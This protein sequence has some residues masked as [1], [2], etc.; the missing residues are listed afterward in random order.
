MDDYGKVKQFLEE[1]GPS[2]ALVVS[3]ATGVKPEIIKLFL[4]KGRVEIP[5]GSQYYLK[6][7]KCA[8][9]IR[10]G[11]YC[12]QCVKEMAGS[13]QAVFNEEVGERPKHE[14]N[15]EM[16]G[17]MHYFDRKIRERLY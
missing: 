6:C 1:N 16:Q 9:S 14:L 2:P 12:P 13:I 11:R 7:E 15:P 3:R 10:Y 5:E 8:C 4:I 17:K